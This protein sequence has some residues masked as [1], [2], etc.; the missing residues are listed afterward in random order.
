MGRYYI[1]II[2]YTKVDG[3]RSD[4]KLGTLS[5]G[6]NTSDNYR[7]RAGRTDLGF[8]IE[9][10]QCKSATF[11]L[12]LHLGTC[13]LTIL[14]QSI[15]LEKEPKITDDPRGVYLAA[16]AIRILYDLGLGSEMHMIGHGQSTL[17]D[18][19]N[20]EVITH[21]HLRS[22]RRTVPSL[23]LRKYACPNHESGPRYYATKCINRSVTD[24]ASSWYVSKPLTM[25]FILMTRA[26][27]SLCET[28]SLP[29]SSVKCA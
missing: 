6:T 26:Q 11:E 2:S 29:A 14:M 27:R 7:R 23:K 16:D 12:C 10:P 5:N 4:I 3:D 9:S 19:E 1:A 25:C 8:G 18:V 24:A 13:V 17:N 20:M 22:H 28:Q 15:I 21:L